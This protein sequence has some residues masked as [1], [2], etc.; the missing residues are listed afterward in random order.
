MAPIWYYVF[1]CKNLGP[2]SLL[3]ALARFFPKNSVGKGSGAWDGVS[4]K[5]GLN[6]YLRFILR[7]YQGTFS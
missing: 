2:R 6:F 7:S 4:L 1:S 3:F 5:Y